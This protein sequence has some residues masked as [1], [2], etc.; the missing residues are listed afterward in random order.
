MSKGT[1]AYDTQI[2]G[3]MI[4][5]VCLN[6]DIF[7]LPCKNVDIMLVKNTV[8]DVFDRKLSDY[9]FVLLSNFYPD[10]FSV[11]ANIDKLTINKEYLSWLLD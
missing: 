3:R 9:N 11:D 7:H 10:L 6:T 1:I 4:T 2:V 5:E 8:Y